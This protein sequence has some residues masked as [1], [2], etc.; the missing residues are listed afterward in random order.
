MHSIRHLTAKSQDGAVK[1]KGSIFPFSLQI[2]WKRGYKR[3]I[4]DKQGR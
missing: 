2:Y 4:M 1:E 3:V